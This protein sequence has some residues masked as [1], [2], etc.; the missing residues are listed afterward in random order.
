MIARCP[1]PA[2]LSLVTVANEALRRALRDLALRLADLEDSEPPPR[3]VDDA[4]RAGALS[5]GTD[6][7][8][9]TDLDLTARLL[10][11][12]LDRVDALRSVWPDAP[13]EAI[14]ASCVKALD[15][16]DNH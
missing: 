14:A 8:V 6:L 12:G 4:L 2:T 11:L 10:L 16:L 13:L 9:V 15:R 1:A 7:D 5:N 3:S